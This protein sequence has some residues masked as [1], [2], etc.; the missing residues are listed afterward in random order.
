MVKPEDRAT[1]K[2]EDLA[3]AVLVMLTNNISSIAQLHANNHSLTH[4]LYTGN[5]LTGNDLAKQTLAY[6]AD[7]W[8]G[9]A[10]KAL[11]LEHEG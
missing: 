7:F 11:F 2:E 9:G 6:A 4:I 8:S 3:K 5:F 10:R 1:A